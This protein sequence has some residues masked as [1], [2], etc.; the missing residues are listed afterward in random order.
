[1]RVLV[2]GGTRFIG[3][4]LVEL[5]AAREH[6]VVV[7]SRDKLSLH[8]PGPVKAVRGER[9][10]RTA[11]ERL[12]SGGGYDCVVDNIAFGS[13]AVS[14]LAA[15]GGDRIGRYVLMSTAWVYAVL[16]PEVG[17]V[18]AEN[19]L[20][21]GSISL[22]YRAVAVRGLP[23]LTRRYIA[24]KIAA[25]AAAFQME[26][27]VTI[28]RPAMVSGRIDHNDRIGFYV[29][30][31]MDG[32]PVLLL[33]GGGQ[34]F[35][36]LWVDDLARSMVGLIEADCP[37]RSVFNIAPSERVSTAEIVSLIEEGL[38]RSVEKVSRSTAVLEKEYPE[39]ESYEPFAATI[40][41]RYDSTEVLSLLPEFRFT[42]PD[43]WIKE[44]VRRLAEDQSGGKESNQRRRE[45]EAAKA[46]RRS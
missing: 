14:E 38:G 13:A 41:D 2:L 20:R 18:F 6:E 4:R 8:L 45:R 30:R 34:P 27:P 10:D 37:R 21:P 12:F 19:D 5:L 11:L 33:E 9:A 3:R 17:R 31:V 44:C 25:E 1:M 32:G 28:L 22:P 15:L 42:A 39:Y 35:H 24:E 16:P 7:F 36:L 43:C 46:D 29:R 26:V 23:D 40:K